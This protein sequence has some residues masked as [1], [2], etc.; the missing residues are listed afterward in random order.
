MSV[1]ISQSSYR[2][3]LCWSPIKDA[4]SIIESFTFY[5]SY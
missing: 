1:Q 5:C 4:T 3:E 2:A